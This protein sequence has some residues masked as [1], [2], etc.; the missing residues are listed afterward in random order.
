MTSTGVVS[1]AAVIA[2]QINLPSMTVT[3][4]TLDRYG[5]SG[6]AG[7]EFK[8]ALYT[9]SGNRPD[10]LVHSIDTR[11][12]ALGG[13]QEVDVTNT[14]L[15]AGTYWIAVRAS[16]NMTIPLSNTGVTTTR[17][18]RNITIA[19]LDSA[20]PP[21]FGASSCATAA[22]TNVYIVTYR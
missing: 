22:A 14:P 16:P 18:A 10:V 6:T 1:N 2:Y 7:S 8:M 9:D 19:S 12:A 4:S 5:I 21:M 13:S 20:W 15:S 11:I 3:A 17:C